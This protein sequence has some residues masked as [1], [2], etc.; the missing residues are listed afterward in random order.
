MSDCAAEDANSMQPTQ[1]EDLE[2]QIAT[3]KARLAEQERLLH[4]ARLR[5]RNYS[6]A[7]LFAFEERERRQDLWAK[8]IEQPHHKYLDSGELTD[9]SGAGAIVDL[10]LD[11]NDESKTKFICYG[12]SESEGHKEAPQISYSEILA[13]SSRA[14]LPQQVDSNLLKSIRMPVEAEPYESLDQLISDISQLI[15]RCVAL[16]ET[17]ARLLAHFVLST[18]LIDR[19]PVAPYLA[20]VGP[21]QSGKTKLLRVLHLLCRRSLFASDATSVSLLRA[22]DQ[23]HPTLLIDETSSIKDPVALRRLLR[24]GNTPGSLVLRHKQSWNVFGAKVICWRELPDDA[25][26]N[27][28]CIILP[29]HAVNDPALRLPD[30]PEIVAAATALHSQL[31]YYRLSNY[32]AVVSHRGT[33]GLQARA[34]EASSLVNYKA[35]AVHELE[36]SEN[37]SARKRELYFAL[38]APCS[39][40]PQAQQAQRFILEYLR[41]RDLG[42]ED[43]LSCRIL[44]PVCALPCGAPARASRPAS[45]QRDRSTRKPIPSG[46][47]RAHSASDPPRRL[48]RYWLCLRATSAHKAW[49]GVGAPERGRTSPSSHRR[50]QRN[51]L[52][53]RRDARLRRVPALPRRAAQGPGSCGWCGD[54]VNVVN[55]ESVNVVNVCE[56]LKNATFITYPY[57]SKARVN[58]V[59]VVRKYFGVSRTPSAKLEFH[60]GVPNERLFCGRWGD[61]TS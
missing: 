42:C 16:S 60:V 26:L 19:L 15:L 56:R 30:D 35:V 50:T 51:G 41:A 55:L 37:L 45:H 52:P 40:D 3:Q 57:E 39:P 28:R 29:M 20:L 61:C 36:L 58:V 1:T 2:Q 59:N 17:D 12:P 25:A 47:T 44:G 8:I 5:Y 22:C 23:L 54:R 18:W 46:S 49:L 14:Y 21:P 7:S 43:A 10:V 53:S 13:D 33:P 32:N 6:D 9:G 27:S 48:H 31:L 11:L 38:A 24:I 34:S 4:S